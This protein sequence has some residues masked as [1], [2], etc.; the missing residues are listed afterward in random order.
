ME[1]KYVWSK[2]YRKSLIWNILVCSFTI[3]CL[4]G[5][6]NASSTTCNSCADCSS[7]LN[8]SYD[9][10]L[11][12][13]SL[14]NSGG[15]CITFNA[16]S[17]VFDCQ[18]NMISGKSDY[19]IYLNG[20]SN[21]TIRNCII[22]DFY[23]GIYLDN[24]DFNNLINNRIANNSIGVY[25]SSD[26]NNN[27]LT[28]NLICSSGLDVNDDDSNSG[29]ENTCDKPDG[30]NDGGTIGCTY[31]CSNPTM[32]SDGT[33][34]GECSATQ[35][36]Y[37]DNG[38]LVDNCGSCGCPTGEEFNTT[39]ESFYV[40]GLV[41][42][43]PPGSIIITE[44][45]NNPSAVSDANGEYIELYNT[46]NETYDLNGLIIKD[47]GTNSHTISSSLPIA[48]GEYVVLCR[49]SN[50]S[51]NGGITCDY[52]YGNS[53]QLAN[54]DDEVILEQNGTI[55]DQVYYDGGPVW[56]DPNGASMNLDPGAFDAIL[57][58]NG[59]NWCESTTTFENGDMGTPRST[60]DECISTIQTCSD[61][62]PYGNCSTT[63]PLYCDN[64]TLID[65]CQ[66]CGCPSGQNCN[67]TTGSCYSSPI[68]IIPPKKR[69]ASNKYPICVCQKAVHAVDTNDSFGWWLAQPCLC[70]DGNRN[71][72]FEDVCTSN[73]AWGYYWV[74]T[75]HNKCVNFPE[76]ATGNSWPTNTTIILLF[77][78]MMPMK[79]V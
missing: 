63:K 27:N 71:F 15:T 67:T 51:K 17:I 56:P 23:R 57:N 21:N 54:T 26:S 37:C 5:I 19:G 14:S 24:S 29:D 16:N 62:T 55:I 61:G 1:E 52:Q 50:A 66:V 36:L 6:V 35:P 43:I 75:W 60:N 7:K 9:L 39:T 79:I 4:S 28:S 68:V 12:N 65:N 40:S 78:K 45:M 32:C 22:T 74:F 20:R 11:L 77:E 64:G 70:L 42:A 34:Y 69:V 73:K 53:F 49:N 58:D 41:S 59:S 31:N 25:F 38:T 46:E 72:Y 13:T 8:G 44:I 2:T 3:F 18:K 33:P 48:P 10:V 76:N 47:N 30:W